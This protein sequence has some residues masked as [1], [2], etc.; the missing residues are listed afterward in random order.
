MHAEGDGNKVGETNEGPDE[1]E[2]VGSNGMREGHRQTR[3]ENK[4]EVKRKPSCMWGGI[5]EK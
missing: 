5:D 4:A 1:K 2:N 3:A